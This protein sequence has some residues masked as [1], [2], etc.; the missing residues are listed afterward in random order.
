[1]DE[2]VPTFLVEYVVAVNSV[3]LFVMV[4]IL[5]ANSAS[6]VV[7]EIL[8][9]CNAAGT[10]LWA[11]TCGLGLLVLALTFALALSSLLCPLH[12]GLLCLL[13][14][15]ERLRHEPVGS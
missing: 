4:E 15:V 3:Y 9:Y 1:M 5:H 8:M 12:V 6:C 7:T 13:D 11:F 10:A 14:F 2:F